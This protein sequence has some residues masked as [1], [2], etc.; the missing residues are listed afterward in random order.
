MLSALWQPLCPMMGLWPHC[1]LP[2]QLTMHAS[3]LAPFTLSSYCL[4]IY[5]TVSYTPLCPSTQPKT[6]QGAGTLLT[7]TACN[8]SGWRPPT[9]SSCP[10]RQ[11]LLYHPLLKPEQ[12]L[13]FKWWLSSSL[14]KGHL[15]EIHKE[16]TVSFWKQKGFWSGNTSPTFTTV[17]DPQETQPFPLLRCPFPWPSGF[18]FLGLWGCGSEGAGSAPVMVETGMCESLTQSRLGKSWL[19]GRGLEALM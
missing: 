8:F 5:V 2:S 1:P 3:I 7:C 6:R 12:P 15:I 17:L 10:P 13:S 9:F 19:G 14:Q 11:H 16:W 18:P 4:F